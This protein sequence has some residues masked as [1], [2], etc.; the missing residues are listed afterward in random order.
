M[1][2]L[3]VPR[4]NQTKK[5]KEEKRKASH[6]KAITPHCDNGHSLGRAAGAPHENLFL[7][8]FSLRLNTIIYYFT[9]CLL[10][11]T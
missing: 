10:I 3:S 8:F 11:Q 9:L 6:N 7:S 4:E 2:L 1:S 5:K